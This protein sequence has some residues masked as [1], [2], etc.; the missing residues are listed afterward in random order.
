MKG[1]AS[2]KGYLFSNKRVTRV[3]EGQPHYNCQVPHA[4]TVTSPFS[5]HAYETY[6]SYLKINKKY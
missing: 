1:L 4:Q 5:S 2:F 3:A 6:F